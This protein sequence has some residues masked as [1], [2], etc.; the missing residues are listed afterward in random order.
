VFFLGRDADTISTF[1]D[2]EGKRIGIGPEGSGTER[3]AYQVLGLEAGRH[4]SRR[5]YYWLPAEGEPVKLTHRIEHWM[6]D[7]LP[8]TPYNPEA[9]SPGVVTGYRVRYEPVPPRVYFDPDGVVPSGSAGDAE[10]RVIAIEQADQE[11]LS[12][13]V[14]LPRCTEFIVEWSLGITDRRDPEN[15]PNYG[16]PIWHGLRRYVDR[17]GDG[18]YDP[19]FA[20]GDDRLLADLFGPTYDEGALNETLLADDPDPTQPDSF[21]IRETVGDWIFEDGNEPGSTNPND[22]NRVIDQEMIELIRV[23][24]RFDNASLPD[25]E[26]AVAAEYCFGYQYQDWNED[27]DG[28]GAFDNDGDDEMRPWPWPKLVRVTMR[29]VDPSAPEEERTYQAEFRVPQPN[30]E[31]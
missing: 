22:V 3:I 27:Y 12:S 29:F 25:P 9:S 4:V 14:F 7:A 21:S 11:M 17:N 16:Q 30:G 5:W 31:M 10:R 8:S 24:Q 13:S 6:L 1:G 23:D 26:D 28:D 18:D 15:N 20:G 19:G 2:L